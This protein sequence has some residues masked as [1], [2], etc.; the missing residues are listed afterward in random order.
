MT[1]SRLA[2]YFVLFTVMLDAIGIGLIMP[3]MP[4]L[5]LELGNADL[6]RAAV[7]GGVL[8]S[9]FAVMQFGFGPMLGNLSDRFGRR[10]ILL[11]SLFLMC[12][13][14]LIMGFA[15]SIWVLFIGRIVHGITAANHSTA[16]AVIADVSKPENKA[17]NFG[18]LGAAFGVGFIMGPLLG[19]L[20]SEWSVR[21]PFFG[22][23]VLVAINM[24][25]GY[26]VLIETVTAD[27]RRPFR[28]SRANPFGAFRALSALPG[29]AR[30]MVVV[31]LHEMSFIVYPVVWAYYTLERYGWDAKMVGISLAFFGFLLA[32]VQGGLTRVL[33]PRFGEYR[34]TVFGLWINVLA[35]VLVAFNPLGWLVFVFLPLTT[36]GEVSSPAI[37]GIM[38]R[39]VPND[40]QGELQGIVTSIRAVA[41][42]IGPLLMT[43]LF[44]IF[45][46]EGTQFYFPGA[47][48]L[49]AMMFALAAL[50]VL[51]GVKEKRPAG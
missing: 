3:V 18:L 14:Y 40:A 27:K 10:P 51:A 21:A 34:V 30:M 38:S 26:F 29:Q 7:W 19:G 28:W 25:F 41:M 39:A 48:F 47:P 17:A 49:M 50:V 11:I 44:S 22:A 46:R 23:A 16:A 13:D 36:L 32:L 4:Q 35:F 6:S 15:G 43:G 20:L 1:N 37:Q 31:F 24:V 45:T 33:V 5:L 2:V 8:S 9:V 42:I 12:V